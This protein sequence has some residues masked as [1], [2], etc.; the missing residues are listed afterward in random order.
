MNN[1][2]SLA[3]LLLL[4]IETVPQYEQFNQ[5]DIGWQSLWID[6]ISKTVPENLGPAESYTARAGILAEFGKIICIS[7]AYFYENE[8]KELCLKI[9]SFYGHNE[10]EL[11]ESFIQA[12][13]RLYS[14]K[15]QFKFCG[16]NIKEFDIPYICRRMVIQ[17]MPLPAYLN[18]HG[19]KP[20]EVNMVDTLQWWKFGDY[21]NYISLNLLAHVLNVPTSKTDIDGSMVQYVYYKDNNLPRIVEYCQRDVVAVA[22]IMLR[23]KN[24]PLLDEEK[25]LVVT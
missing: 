10:K 15:K 14:G 3:D 19:A 13:S 8:Y 4:D 17:Q 20:W 5:M 7:T 12:C 16:H 11:L 18:I 6:K 1:D 9:K 22:N 21:K 2:F 23:F 24:Q 25:I